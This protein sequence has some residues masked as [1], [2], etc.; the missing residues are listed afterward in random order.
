M[1]TALKPCA[2]YDG[3][4]ILKYSTQFLSHLRPYLEN[5]TLNETENP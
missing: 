1:R 4:A 3:G 2:A 5:I